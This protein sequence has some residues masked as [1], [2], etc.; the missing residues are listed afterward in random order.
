[1]DNNPSG[2]HRKLNVDTVNASSRT[3]DFS[4]IIEE[5]CALVRQS[6]QIWQIAGN[7][8]LLTDE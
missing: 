2:K 3:T 5:T 1:M 4:V 7:P 6:I 8:A